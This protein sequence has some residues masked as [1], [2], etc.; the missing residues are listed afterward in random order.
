MSNFWEFIHCSSPGSSVHGI[1]QA[2][3]LEWVA[4]SFYR[5]FPDPGPGNKP[6]SL[7]LQ[8]LPCI[9]GGFFTSWATRGFNQYAGVKG[10]LLKKD[11]SQTLSI[12]LV[13]PWWI[14]VQFISVYQ[15]CLTLWPHELQHARLPCP[16]PTPEAYSNYVHRVSDAIQPSHP[17]LSPSPPTFNLFQHQ[18][19]FQRA[20]SSYQ[21]VKVLE[22]QPQHQSFQWI[23]RTT[24]L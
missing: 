13:E 16:S 2:R 6:R 8:A 22:F 1:S 11:H 15:S 4:I 23:F 3:I 10:T 12:K 5:D 20:S 24:F 14:S 19:L 17:L 7:A 21:V 18:G 9:T